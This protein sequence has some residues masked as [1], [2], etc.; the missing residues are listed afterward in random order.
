M[1]AIA[2]ILAVAASS[3]AEARAI[4]IISGTYGTKCGTPRGD[5]TH[6]LARQCDGL[7]TCPYIL[8]KALTGAP[9][10]DCHSDHM[11]LHVEWLCTD[12]EFHT[13]TISAEAGPG[14]RLVL[15]CV[16]ETGPGR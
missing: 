16:E 14:S 6:D 7:Q 1:W 10:K 2:G 13:A 15:S 3:S 5:A 9:S 12:T 4:R 11:D 8:R